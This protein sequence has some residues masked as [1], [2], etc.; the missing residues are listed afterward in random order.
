MRKTYNTHLKNSVW[1][2]LTT[3][4]PT[5]THR[6]KQN[7]TLNPI[8]QLCIINTAKEALEH[9]EH[10]TEQQ[11]LVHHTSYDGGSIRS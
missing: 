2:R 4:A 10:P 6:C 9:A 3:K 7:V 5:N 8:E 1:N 11:T